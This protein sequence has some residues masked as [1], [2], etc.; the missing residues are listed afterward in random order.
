MMNPL[1]LWAKL[2]KKIRGSAIIDSRIDKSSKIEAGSTIVN[3]TFDRHSFCGYDCMIINC[4]VGAFCSI[5][6]GV[7]IGGARH[8]MEYASTSPVFLSHKDSVKMKYARHDYSLK[9]R[10]VVDSDVWI[11]EVALI[12]AGVHIGVGAVIGM[13]SVVTRDVEPYSVVAG[14]PARTIRKRFDDKTIKALLELKWWTLP[15]SKLKEIAVYFNDVPKLL[16]RVRP[17]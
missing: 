11:G 3:S 1:Y 4:T 16:E 2:I 8:P 9:L 12:K 5:A 13:G 7:V 15:D 6:N 14:N 17:K 10:T